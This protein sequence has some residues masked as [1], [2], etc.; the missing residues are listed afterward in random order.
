V[1]ILA[2]NIKLFSHNGFTIVG[3]EHNN[4]YVLYDRF[5]ESTN[6][7]GH[8]Y[9][10]NTLTRWASNQNIT[11]NMYGRTRITKDNFLIL[12]AKKIAIDLKKKVIYQCNQNEIDVFVQNLSDRE[13]ITF[14]NK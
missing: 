1:D 11:L 4:S 9:S 10:S 14:N 6:Y 12:T 2:T 13:K 8:K 3:E 5:S 7:V